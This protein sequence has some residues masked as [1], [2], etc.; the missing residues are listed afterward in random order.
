MN[1]DHVRPVP[2]RSRRRVVV[3]EHDLAGSARV[4]DVLDANPLFIRGGQSL[5][6]ERKLSIIREEIEVGIEGGLVDRLVEPGVRLPL[7]CLHWT[8]NAG[9]QSYR[10]RDE[11]RY[12]M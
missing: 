11:R 1:Q 10:Q 2:S 4:L 6:V 5:E 8:G 7:L 3:R 9:A 12:S